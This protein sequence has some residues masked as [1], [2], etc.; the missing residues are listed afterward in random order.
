MLTAIFLFRDQ[1]KLLNTQIN[2]NIKYIAR[3]I[4]GKTASRMKSYEQVLRGIKGLYVSKNYNI[5]RHELLEYAAQLDMEK[6]LP[7]VQAVGFSSYI[8]AD[9]VKEHTQHAIADGYPSYALRSD[10][11]KSHY[12]AVDIM[13]PDTEENRRVY[14]FDLSSE[15]VRAQMLRYA[16]SSRTTGLSGKI[17]LKQE[18]TDKNAPAGVLM[19]VPVFRN[20]ELF[21]VISAPFRINDL[22]FGIFRGDMKD[23][24]VRIYDSAVG[25]DNILY[26]TD[27]Y[28]DKVQ[29]HTLTLPI[30][31]YGRVW[32]IEADATAQ[33][34]SQ[35][36]NSKPYVIFAGVFV[37]GLL[38]SMLSQIL[39]VTRN[40][41]Y[42]MA[43]RIANRLL[44]SENRFHKTFEQASVG[45]VITSLDL[46]IMSTNS[47]FRD[48]IRCSEADAAGRVLTD[49]I[50]GSDRA[51][52]EKN[53]QQMAEGRLKG[54]KT[55]KRIVSRTNG[56]KWAEINAS[57]YF[58]TNGV[59]RYL[60]FVIQDISRRKTAEESLL[61][62]SMQQA[63][64]LNNSLTAIMKVRN[65][66]VEWVNKAFEDIF[67]YSNAEM[68]GNSTSIL[69]MSDTEY[70]QFGRDV[71]NY[72]KMLKEGYAQ[73]Q[74]EMVRK[75]GSSIWVDISGKLI[76]QTPESSSIWVMND[77][78]SKKEAQD[79]L[80]DL[81]A[82]LECKVVEEIQKRIEQERLFMQQG[83]M[84]AMGEMI[85]AI[86]HQWRQP[87]N[88]VSLVVQNISDD[89]NDSSLTKETMAEYLENVL[90]QLQ[91]MSCT[92]DDFRNFFQIAKDNEE[93]DPA[94]QVIRVLQ[95]INAQLRAHDIKVNVTQGAPCA[96][97]GIP[98]ELS[99]VMLN[100]INN[101][102]DAFMANGISGP[103]IEISVGREERE[104]V[105]RILDNGG[106]I[107]D[108][109]K[110][111]IFDPYFTTKRKDIGTGIG[112][113][114]SKMIINDHFRG[115]IDFENKHGGVEFVIRIPVSA[116]GD[117]A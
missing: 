23:L 11:D 108:S 99:Q 86:A 61:E 52:V 26:E 114:M 60:I 5:S 48:I 71:D 58:D 56:E 84:A 95:L 100:V 97:S 22:I 34:L 3:E 102:K 54:Y 78:T 29:G 59:A 57:V 12:I 93:F 91:H 98:N 111:R 39:L 90:E 31:M 2:S 73:T 25:P 28:N 70:E 9:H 43:K 76:G 96:I 7:G 42:A 89:F 40:K 81:N 92:I 94:Y 32:I 55:E 37:I 21:G 116:K 6:N 72:E 13:Y 36:D 35:F 8:S 67:G 47:S 87:L 105:I 109:I 65:R 80:I 14:G 17:V 83:R 20:D 112:L 38:L 77:V 85:G 44:E 68:I 49:F 24:A 4:T 103:R 115:T 33:Y 75:D 63:A 16:V 110:D 74:V 88:I 41:T 79:E 15:P 106:G 117:P 27:N 69:H 66:K 1:E 62:L 50:A 113:Y 10:S 30:E 18:L 19:S 46:R 45:I 64:I 104:A 107:P 101:S 51:E 53:F 82:N